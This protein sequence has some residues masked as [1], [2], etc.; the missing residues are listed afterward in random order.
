M[1]LDFGRQGKYQA[2]IVY[3]EILANRSNQFKTPYLGFRN[4]QSDLAVELDQAGR[5]SGERKQHECARTRSNGW[6]RQLLQHVGRINRAHCSTTG[7]SR[8]H[9]R[10]RRTRFANVNL[11]TKRI[12][13]DAQVTFEPNRNT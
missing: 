7:D 1:S 6:R 10:R 3:D 9:R 5:A 11:A 13:G 4:K 2:R 8:K 12:R